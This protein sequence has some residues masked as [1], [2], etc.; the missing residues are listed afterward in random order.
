M[1][2]RLILLAIILL[3]PLQ[4]K[5]IEP[6]VII[7]EIAW[8]GTGVSSND[9][10][11]ELKNN[12]QDEID[13]TGWRLEAADG[14][15]KI[16][17]GGKISAGGFFLLE[18]TDDESVADIPADQIYTGSLSNSGEWLKLY[19]NQNN[20]IDEINASESW[21]GGD[22]STKQTLERRTDNSW[23]TSLETGGSPKVENSS[24]S[25]GPKE[26]VIDD[27]PEQSLGLLSTPETS[28][29]KAQKGDIVINEILPNPEG[30]DTDEE[31]IELKNISSLPIDL[32]SW[33]IKNAAKQTF[34]IPSLTMMPNSI[35]LFYRRHTNLVLNN[36]AEK[37]TL[38]S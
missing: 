25:S 17:L 6:T 31:F 22:N 29:P 19:D 27:Q 8:M 24:Q 21:P 13:L 36:S 1:K 4:L 30:T 37:I 34:I 16:N 20:L 12:S 9:E 7:N 10:W 3:L 18:R 35:V 26:P 11:I 5:A 23:Q 38:Y 2:T 33:K 14:S 28:T 15:P 32:T